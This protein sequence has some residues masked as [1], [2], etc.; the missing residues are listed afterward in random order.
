MFKNKSIFPL[1]MLYTLSMGACGPK[2]DYLVTIKTSLGNIKLILF[3]DTPL[4]KENFISLAQAGR[5]DSTTFHR[6]IEGFMIQGGDV[7]AKEGTPPSVEAM[8]PAEILPHNFHRRGALAAARNNNPNKSSSECQF[9]IVQGTTYSR[10]ELALDRLQLNKYF[11]RLLEMPEYRELREQIIALQQ[12]QDIDGMEAKMTEVKPLIEK[13]FD[14]SL[15]REVS[16]P[17]LKAYTSVGGAPH[18]DDEYTV[19]GQVLEG[20]EVV[21]AIAAR[22]KGA[23]DKPLEEVYIS[24]EVEQLPR[25]KIT[26][27]YGYQ[28]PEEK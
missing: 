8:I 10:E 22:P 3:D 4:H 17:R 16:A 6:V 11:G 5:Y 14:I 28:Y 20:L 19:F 15:E 1:L 7:N 13:E 26:K 9:Y 21:D 18:L 12:A 2:K 25:T 24:M 23:A 27:L